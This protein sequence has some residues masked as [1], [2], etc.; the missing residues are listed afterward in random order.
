MNK[1]WKIFHLTIHM[2]IFICLL[3][4]MLFDALI[5]GS[6]WGMLFALIP[7]IT[8]SG[9]IAAIY[10]E[11]AIVA[12]VA[13]MVTVTILYLLGAYLYGLDY[14]DLSM[15]FTAYLISTAIAYLIAKLSIWGARPKKT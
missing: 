1:R 13:T 10:F 6:G 11:R 12:L 2:I 14:G 7:F 8:A 5:V 15:T 3:G 4:I 9:I